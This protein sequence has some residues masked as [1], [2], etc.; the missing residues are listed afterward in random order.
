[1]NNSKLNTAQAKANQNS[2]KH[3]L[4]ISKPLAVLLEAALSLVAVVFIAIGSALAF[5]AQYRW[6]GIFVLI[7]GFWAGAAGLFI[8]HRHRFLKKRL[9]AVARLVLLTALVVGFS[10]LGLSS[11]KFNARKIATHSISLHQQDCLVSVPKLLE[12]YESVVIQGRRSDSRGGRLCGRMRTERNT[13]AI[14]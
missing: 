1:M 2:E 9:P 10:T 12:S 6:A 3:G 13:T 5:D 7:G 8:H 4:Y 14:T 11:W